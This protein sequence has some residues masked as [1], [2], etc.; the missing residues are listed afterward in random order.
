MIFL[1]H[2]ETSLG[3][4]L[5]LLLLLLFPAFDSAYFVKYCSYFIKHNSKIIFPNE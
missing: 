2:S 4:L 5:F 3:L 1:T